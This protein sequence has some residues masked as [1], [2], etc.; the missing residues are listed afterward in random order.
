MTD[1]QHRGAPGTPGA[2]EP[3]APGE[4]EDATGFVE[5]PDELTGGYPDAES[6]L[7]AP[8]HGYVPPPITVNP[9]AGDSADPAGTGVWGMSGGPGVP[10]GGHP[11]AE[12]ADP[13][14]QGAVHW[15]DPNGHPSHDTS[16]NPGDPGAGPSFQDPYGYDPGMTQTPGPAGAH[17]TGSEGT[18]GPWHFDDAPG[19][20]GV[21]PAGHGDGTGAD[22]EGGA[23]DTQG[24]W[25]IPLAQG[26]LPDETGEFTTS[27]LAA[28]WGGVPPATLPG[29]ATAPWATGSQAGPW[30]P[31]Q[32][33]HDEPTPQEPTQAHRM[34]QG[35]RVQRAGR[36]GP[37]YPA[38]YRDESGEQAAY[39]DE[40]GQ[41]PVH[42]Y[43]EQAAGPHQAAPGQVEEEQFS[44]ERFQGSAFQEQHGQDQAFHDQPF[45]EGPFPEPS[46]QDQPFPPEHAAYPPEQ[47]SEQEGLP[48][49]GAPGAAPD[50]SQ[51]QFADDGG[52][53]PFGEQPGA[54]DGDDEDIYLGP[55]PAAPHADTGSPGD[56]GPHAAQ[57]AAGNAPFEAAPPRAPRKR[58]PTRRPLQDTRV[59][60]P[61]PE[62]LPK[63]H[64]PETAGRRR[65]ARDGRQPS[66]ANQQDRPAQE[67]PGTD[68]DAPEATPQPGAPH[69]SQEAAAGG[70]LADGD[71]RPLSAGPDE[72]FPEPSEAAPDE[73][74]SVPPLEDVDP[75]SGAPQDASGDAVAEATAPDELAQAHSEEPAGFPEQRSEQRLEAAAGAQ[76]DPAGQEAAQYAPD[77][78]DGGRGDEESTGPH[79][80]QDDRPDGAHDDGQGERPGGGQVTGSDA[81]DLGEEV[82]FVGDEHP[83][84]SYVLRVNG[85]D[86]PVTDAWVGE[87]LLY[88]LRERLGLAG[89][90]D[91]CSQGECGA[92]NVQVD[93]RLVASCL[94]PAAIT[95]GSDVRTVEG[96]AADGQPSDVQRALAECGAVQ[97]GFCVPG[98]AMTVH[99]LLDGNPDPTDLETRHALAGNLCR[100]SGYRGVLDAVRRVVGE[101]RATDSDGAD[102]EDDEDTDTSGARIPHQA[103]P[104]AGGVSSSVAYAA[105][106]TQAPYRDAAPY[107]APYDQVSYEDDGYDDGGRA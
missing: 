48:D 5:L 63:G 55:P 39:H 80:G 65:P 106:T 22:P 62:E 85:T 83:L 84:G 56:A 73:P 33:S 3:I 101:R 25:S 43:P 61:L 82:V 103:S 104:G 6:P 21:A 7:A 54:Q 42:S 87:S 50:A 78:L 1:D 60:E 76:D 68:T 89:A 95:A 44:E 31:A 100:C 11:G 93:G 97:C 53:A 107:A 79:R 66:P 17:G 57:A 19:D 105:R 46:F 81:D 38:E 8:G 14:R 10:A 23:A 94:V 74:G 96:L 88:V 75:G 26:D 18:G 98:M 2:W 64:V 91:G 36:P 99:H 30:D 34:Q 77:G 86:R 13:T 51:G 35:V 20:P 49:E 4:Y 16:P 29:G 32:P 45:R 58:R 69:A 15:P 71:G 52:Q 27:V 70:G 67:G 37:D 40:S 28:Q 12:H 90:K 59:Q 47:F 24:G 72:T 41:H 92:C 102:P 9:A